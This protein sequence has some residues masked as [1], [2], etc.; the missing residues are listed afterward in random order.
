MTFAQKSVISTAILF[1]GLASNQ[2]L[3]QSPEEQPWNAPDSSPPPLFQKQDLAPEAI[4]RAFAAKEAEFYRAWIQYTYRQTVVY[5]ILS[6]NGRASNERLILVSEIYFRDSGT[7]EV[8]IVQRSGSLR[9]VKFSEEDEEVINNLQ[10]FALTTKELP[11]YDLK[12]EGKA[13]LDELDCYRFS[14]K[15]K[16]Y[17]GNRLYFEGEIWVDDRDLQVVMTKGKPVPQKRDDNLF[18]D[19]ETRR[20]IIDGKYWFPTWTH[21]DSELNFPDQR[22]HVEETIIYE[23]FRRFGSDATI[24]FDPPK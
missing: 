23:N 2:V 20:E 13:R 3:P 6:V 9:S 4:I 7:R 5:R 17:K 14:V 16:S 15:P 10:P 24:K 1:F 18:P 19:F 22:V 21:A 12:Y 11:L 8:R